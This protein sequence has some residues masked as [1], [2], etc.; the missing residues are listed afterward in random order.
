LKSAVLSKA[1]GDLNRAQSGPAENKRPHQ[2]R[3]IKYRHEKSCGPAAVIDQWSKRPRDV[4]KLDLLG[5]S[6]DTAADCCSNRQFS[7]TE[8]Q[9]VI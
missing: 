7:K 3:T 6:Y 9:R 1:Q 8:V 2:S 5:K 4:M